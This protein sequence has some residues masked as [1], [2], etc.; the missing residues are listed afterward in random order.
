[1]WR[2]G[3]SYYQKSVILPLNF[4]KV[5]SKTVSSKLKFNNKLENKLIYIYQILLQLNIPKL[6]VSMFHSG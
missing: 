3:R 4:H 6:R 5:F 2:I 1:M